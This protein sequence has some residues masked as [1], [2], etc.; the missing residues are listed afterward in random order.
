LNFLNAI[1]AKYTRAGSLLHAMLPHFFRTHRQVRA[2][3]SIA[4]QAVAGVVYL[5]EPT[6]FSTDQFSV[7]IEELGELTRGAT[8]VDR[9]PFAATRRDLEVVT[10]VEVDAVRDCVLNGL[11][12][13]GQCTEGL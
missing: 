7:E 12:F 4:L 8:I 6:L 1:P 13:A 3:E 10:S 9:R 11:R 2:Q 5:L